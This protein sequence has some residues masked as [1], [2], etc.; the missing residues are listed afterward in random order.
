VL[1]IKVRHG[2]RVTDEE[3]A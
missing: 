2:H 1:D 3:V